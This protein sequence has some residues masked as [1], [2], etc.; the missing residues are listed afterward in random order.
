MVMY[1]KSSSLNS[2]TDT[3]R[4]ADYDDDD[5][6]P[7]IPWALHIKQVSVKSEPS[8]WTTVKSKKKSK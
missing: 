1:S 2:P 6:L 8:E 4:W 7:I 3:K 5:L